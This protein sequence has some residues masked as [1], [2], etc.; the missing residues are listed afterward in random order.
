MPRSRGCPRDQTGGI[1]RSVWRSLTGSLLALALALAGPPG[2]GEPAST[3]GPDAA[4]TDAEVRASDTAPPAPDATPDATQAAPLAW[5]VV[6]DGHPAGALLSMWAGGPDDVW[7]V[8]GERHTPKVLHL[9][10]AGWTSHDPGT[11]QQ[12]WWVH[13]FA[14][15]ELVIVG[16]GGSIVR[17]VGG[18]WV[19]ESPGLPGA[20][21]YG[22]WGDS[23]DSL[24][25]V[26]GPSL[27]AEA[28][29]GPAIE[30]DVLL[31]YDGTSWEPIELD[32]GG[33]RSGQS[34]FKV[35]GSA[36][37]NVY[38]VGSDGLILH[39]DGGGWAQEMVEGLAS[40]SLFTVAGRSADDVWA[41][42]G[43]PRGVLLHREAGAWSEVELPAFTPQ[44]L[45]GLRTAPGRPV[46][47]GGAY[48]FTARLDADGWLVP[49]PVTPHVLHAVG[50]DP[51]GGTWAVGGDIM[52]LSP[53]YAGTL[54][55]AG[56]EA[57]ALEVDPPEPDAAVAA[58]DATDTPG[59]EDIGPEDVGPEDTGPQDAGPE[60][61]EP[62][63]G[64]DTAPDPI[65]GPAD[66]ACPE[67]GKPYPGAPCVGPLTC[68]IPNGT[69]SM[70]HFVCEDGV[71]T[72]WSE[73][74]VTGCV[75]LPPISEWCVEPFGGHVSPEG[76]EVSLGPAVDDAGY[77]PFEPGELAPVTW[78]PQG[79]PMLGFRLAFTGADE[80]SCVMLTITATL[81]GIDLE[82]SMTVTVRC[83]QSLRVFLV[84][85]ITPLEC[86]VG[87]L[88]D[89]ELFAIVSGVGSTVVEVQV[90]GGGAPWCD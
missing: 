54:L 61:V 82:N 27:S 22:V 83:G 13:G 30:G 32:L 88:F 9:G 77:V 38:V 43:G 7:F 55:V 75:P 68:D 23:P 76:V 17:R 71:W 37:D 50:E 84:L 85:P 41:V 64:E 74:F 1:L 79:M 70:D 19:D 89:L 59:V 28:D 12:A 42:G 65:C 31:R 81:A 53:S 44:I 56:R 8:G 36:A 49:D 33:E 60:D 6:V 39:Y 58:E 62:D 87:E 90:E 73:C 47:V 46:T 26:G 2:C 48:G 45:Q 29:M 3:V 11:G 69:Y 57:P 51:G 40:I 35:W 34:L 52:I 72:F 18:V 5:S 21:L 10:P 86:S 15:G 14:S 66:V 78:G 67:S 63:A 16:D 25:A 24:W 20:T 4:D 80:L